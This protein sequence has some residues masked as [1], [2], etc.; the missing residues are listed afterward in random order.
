M[1][2]SLDVE[3]V[4]QTKAHIDAD[5]LDEAMQKARDLAGDGRLLRDADIVDVQIE[6][7]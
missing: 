7:A 2:Y 5:S 4:Y 6:E 3:M 1:I